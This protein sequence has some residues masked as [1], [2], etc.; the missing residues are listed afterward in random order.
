MELWAFITLGP[1]VLILLMFM[2]ST[3]Q[4]RNLMSKHR[5]ERFQQRDYQIDELFTD[6]EHSTSP[7]QVQRTYSVPL[8]SGFSCRFERNPRRFDPPDP[9][10]FQTGDADFDQRIQVICDQAEFWQWLASDPTARQAILA[11]LASYTVEYVEC[12]Q[13]QLKVYTNQLVQLPELAPALLFQV[14]DALQPLCRISQ[15][16]RL[17]PSTTAPRFSLAIALVTMLLLLDLYRSDGAFWQQHITHWRLLGY[18]LAGS[19][20]LYV[21]SYR[22]LKTWAGNSL[23]RHRV[24]NES[25]LLL[26]LTYPLLLCKFLVTVNTSAPFDQGVQ[27]QA[28]VLQKTEHWSRRYADSYSVTLIQQQPVFGVFPPTDWAIDAATY[29]RINEQSAVTLTIQPGHLG[30]PYVQRIQFARARTASSTP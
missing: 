30:L 6:N 27:V 12:D 17:R 26:W 21:L 25:L 11:I 16:T 4:P 20:L 9:A 1:A 5:L 22:R 13:D 8:P 3:A 14:V 24:K 7:L 28:Q 2:P 15:Q 23:P 10:A 29:Q 19:V 18:T